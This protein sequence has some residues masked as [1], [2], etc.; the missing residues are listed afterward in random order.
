M[1]EPNRVFIIIMI[2]IKESRF[3]LENKHY[4]SRYSTRKKMCSPCSTADQSKTL[5]STIPCGF[6]SLGPAPLR[7]ESV[8]CQR[9]AS[10]YMGLLLS[11]SLPTC[12]L[13]G[14]LPYARLTNWLTVFSVT[15]E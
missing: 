11:T 9:W 6:A 12:S 2:S 10:G 8:K 14:P 3:I 7:Q 5:S 4:F 15:S 1:C 13:S